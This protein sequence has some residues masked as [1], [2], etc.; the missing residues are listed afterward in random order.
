M[1]TM[2]I[3]TR[4]KDITETKIVDCEREMT[5]LWYAR[6]ACNYAY[7]V[8]KKTLWCEHMKIEIPFKKNIFPHCETKGS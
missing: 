7:L 1:G 4:T 3:K 5:F 6:C 8:K 2:G